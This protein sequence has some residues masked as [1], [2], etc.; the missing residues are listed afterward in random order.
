MT[1]SGR[2]ISNNISR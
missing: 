2:L 1:F